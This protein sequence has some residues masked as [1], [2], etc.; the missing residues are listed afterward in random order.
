MVSGSEGDCGNDWLSV[1]TQS[2]EVEWCN[3]M[4]KIKLM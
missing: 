1:K 4:T 3:K 2:H